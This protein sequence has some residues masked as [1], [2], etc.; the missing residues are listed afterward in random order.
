MPQKVKSTPAHGLRSLHVRFRFVPRDVWIGI[1]V[2][3]QRWGEAEPWWRARH[4][5]FI[6][7]IPMLPVIVEWWTCGPEA[8]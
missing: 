2:D 5:I 3:T 7:L 1:Y 4:R 6:C 8:H